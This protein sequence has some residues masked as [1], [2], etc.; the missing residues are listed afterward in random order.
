VSAYG[1]QPRQAHLAFDKVVLPSGA[2]LLVDSASGNVATGAPP[3]TRTASI[4]DYRNPAH[5]TDRV[6]YFHTK[7][8]NGVMLD[9]SARAFADVDPSWL[10][11]LP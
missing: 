1:G 9:G 11:P 4:L 8:F 5:I 7:K 3:P 2:N 6:G 10:N